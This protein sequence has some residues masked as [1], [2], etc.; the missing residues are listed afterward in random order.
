MTLWSMLPKEEKTQILDRLEVIKMHNYK[1]L[2]FQISSSIKIRFKFVAKIHF[3]SRRQNYIRLLW[4]NLSALHLSA[5]HFPTLYLS[6][7]HLEL[8]LS[9]LHL[10]Q[11]EG[12]SSTYVCSTLRSAR[13]CQLYTQISPRPMFE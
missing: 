13:G 12:V 7:L 6:A 9:A 5:L 8:H 4:H 2:F 10:D 11:L 3:R 1:I